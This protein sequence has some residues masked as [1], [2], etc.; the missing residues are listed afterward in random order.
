MLRD[1]THFQFDSYVWPEHKLMLLIPYRG[2]GGPPNLL[3]CILQNTTTYGALYFIT[4]AH[5]YCSCRTFLMATLYRTRVDSFYNFIYIY[6]Y[7]IFFNVRNSAKY[8]S[9]KGRTR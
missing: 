2:A 3:V 7:I 6:I 1:V 4:A 9:V 8:P 5:V